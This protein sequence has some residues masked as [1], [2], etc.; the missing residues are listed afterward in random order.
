MSGSAKAPVAK[1]NGQ[2]APEDENDI[3]HDDSEDDKEDQG[4]AAGAGAETGLFA[5]LYGR[6][7][8]TAT[9]GILSIQHP[10]SV[11][12]TVPLITIRH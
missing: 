10:P 5:A 2:T 6:S 11:P 7:N 8:L 3:D 1:A 12:M 9:S 4:A